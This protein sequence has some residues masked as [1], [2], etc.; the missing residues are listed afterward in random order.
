MRADA[1]AFKKLFPQQHIPSILASLFQA[2]E[3]L[4]KRAEND[5]EDWITRRLYRRL[6]IIPT[7]RD[8]PLGIHL[9]PEI[10]SIELDLDTHT[11]EIDLFVSCGLGYKVYFPI[12]AKRLRVRYSD[13]K[14][15]TGSGAYVNDGMMRFIT[16]QYS[17]YM[18][19]AA[20]LGY[21]F[22]G[23]IDIARSDIDTVV[24]KKA[25]ELKLK[26][27]RRLSRSNILPGNPVDET[28]HDLEK[29]PFIIYHVFLHI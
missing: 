5:R 1:E 26:S 18:Q 10:I 19:A 2:G 28:H 11:G 17:P 27:P 29:R 20:M 8:G 14:I 24:Q 12:E 22:D 21:V 15:I 13:S 4:R 25:L 6:V 3:T 16:G 23:K 9:K 7:F